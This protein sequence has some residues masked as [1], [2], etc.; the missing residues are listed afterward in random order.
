LTS[1]FYT[2]SHQLRH[3][4]F[5]FLESPKGSKKIETKPLNVLGYT[6]VQ[7]TM[8][9]SNIR[10]EL[11]SLNQEVCQLHSFDFIK[12]LFLSFNKELLQVIAYQTDV[13]KKRDTRLKDLEQYTDSL[14]VKIV[15]QCPTILQVGYS[16]KKR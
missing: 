5:N 13:I 3:F 2:Y 10:Q 11:Q 1:N 12:L 15:E 9:N 8:I 16:T 14:L 6:N 4:R 7:T